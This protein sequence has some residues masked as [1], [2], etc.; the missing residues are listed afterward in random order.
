MAI[1][2]IALLQFNSST[3]G[4]LALARTWSVHWK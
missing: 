4:E 3:I 1:A 2:F